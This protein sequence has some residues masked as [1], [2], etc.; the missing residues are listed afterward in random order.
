MLV[1]EVS[2]LKIPDSSMPIVSDPRFLKSYFNQENCM[3]LVSNS[4]VNEPISANVFASMYVRVF[5]FK[6]L[7]VISVVNQIS[8][9][10][11]QS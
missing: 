6:S 11:K 3:V 8:K 1:V 7:Q 10:V 9:Y 5:K 2:P 4:V